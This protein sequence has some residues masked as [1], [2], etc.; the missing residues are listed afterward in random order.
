VIFRHHILVRADVLRDPAGLGLDDGG[1]TDG[2]EER[3]LA[4][5]DV[6]HDRDARRAGGERLLGVVVRL[7]LGVL[8]AGVLDRHL[9][10]ELGPD[11]LDL[12]VEE[13]LRRGPHL[14]EAHEDLDELGHR[15]A[16]PCERSLTVT[17]DS[18]VIGPDGGGAGGCRG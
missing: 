9:A 15:N 7:G 5:V 3:R 17:P 1:P 16:E 13:R 6:A 12:L 11:Q 8:L 18:T 4:V 14:A 2:V 10:L